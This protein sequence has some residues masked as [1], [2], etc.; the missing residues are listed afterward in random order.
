MK[1]N[2]YLILI[3]LS[4]ATIVFSQSMQIIYPTYGTVLVKSDSLTIQWRVTGDI[5]NNVKIRLYNRE[6]TAKIKDIVNNTANNG[7]YRCPPNFFNDVPDGH[8][9]IRVKT[10]NNNFSNTGGVF[11][12]RTQQDT[13]ES[14]TPPNN[15]TTPVLKVPGRQNLNSSKIKRKLNYAPP[16]IVITHPPRNHKWKLRLGDTALPFP[17]RVMWKKTGTGTQN[18]RVRILLQRISPGLQTTLITQNTANS[19]LFRGR[20][21]RNLMTNVYTIIIETLDG[22][23]RTESEDFFIINAEDDPGNR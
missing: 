22:K 12:I 18:M 1:K 7:T 21:P 2:I 8:Y 14:N 13:D 10:L 6:M 20:I 3:I 9:R 4:M 11:N 15:N 19:G 17:I 5:T 23:I 16:S